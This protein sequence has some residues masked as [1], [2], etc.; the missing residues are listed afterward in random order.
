MEYSNFICE[1][2]KKTATCPTSKLRHARFCSK[3]C[4]EKYRKFMGELRY[5]RNC[6]VCGKKFVFKHST[7]KTNPKYCSQQCAHSIQKGENH[8]CWKGGIQIIEG[9]RWIYSPG[10]PYRV[11]N[12][13][14]EHRLVMEKHIGRYL[15]PTE[16]VHHING[17]PLD[18]RI[19]NLKLYSSPGTHV[20]IEHTDRDKINGRFIPKQK[21]G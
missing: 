17:N 9:Y 1:Y 14:K 4:F 18:N 5:E 11:H 21:N 8:G 15:L 13:V 12:K 20:M 3:D 2:C 6:L 7:L 16:I 19:E 10:H